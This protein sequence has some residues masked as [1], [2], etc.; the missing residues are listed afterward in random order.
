[1]L[2]TCYLANKLTYL[3]YFSEYILYST[4][5]MA[6]EAKATKKTR[7]TMSTGRRKGLTEAET[8]DEEEEEAS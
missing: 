8:E 5:A 6:T 3:E 4:K 1:M 7:R 2:H